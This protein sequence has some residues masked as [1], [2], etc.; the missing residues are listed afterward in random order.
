MALVSVV[1]QP[2]WAQS[3]QTTFAGGNGFHGN[4]FDINATQDVVIE[5][6]E[7]NVDP[8][9]HTIEIYSRGGD[10]GIGGRGGRGED[11]GDGYQ[12]GRGGNAGNRGADRLVPMR[13]HP[14]IRAS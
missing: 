5:G 1:A 14:G 12:G 11:G 3:L 8:G 10:G 7:V 13:H 4:M 2:G 6:F 9:M